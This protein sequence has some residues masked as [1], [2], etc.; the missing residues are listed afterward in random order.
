MW[1]CV[2]M[3]HMDVQTGYKTK[4]KFKITFGRVANGLRME[5]FDPSQVSYESRRASHPSGRSSVVGQPI[6]II[7]PRLERIHS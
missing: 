3:E 4:H 7:L 2:Q 6:C 1:L 5:R